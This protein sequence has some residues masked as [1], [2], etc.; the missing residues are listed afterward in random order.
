MAEQ[1]GVSH[2][3]YISIVG[4]D[5]ATSYP[6]YQ[7]KLDTER[8]VEGSPV[9]YTILR[10][11][12]FHELPFAVLQFLG[13]LPAM[14]LPKGFLLQPIDAGEVANRLTELALS[15]SASRVP[16]VGGPEVSTA[17]ELG[18]SYLEASGRRRRSL[19]VPVPGKV[20]R[21]F[22]EGTQT[23]PQNKYG[24]IT[25]DEFLHSQPAS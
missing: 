18:R 23:C 2:F 17:A 7:V 8:V 16:D 6:Y 15:G 25:W 4:I 19:E 12:Q 13:R 9:P 14:P 1:G 20:G 10:A 3:I 11:T 22:R 21:A 5:H 24:S